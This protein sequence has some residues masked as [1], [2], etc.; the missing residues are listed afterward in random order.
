MAQTADDGRWASVFLINF[1]SPRRHELSC[2]TAAAFRIAELLV[3]RGGR[4]ILLGLS[5]GLSSS[6][7]F[8][9]VLVADTPRHRARRSHRC[10]FALRSSRPTA[11]RHRH[12]SRLTRGWELALRGDRRRSAT[13]NLRRLPGRRGLC[14]RGSVWARYWWRRSIHLGDR[15]SRRGGSPPGDR[16]GLV[17]AGGVANQR[18]GW[19]DSSGCGRSNGWDLISYSFYLWHWPVLTIAA[20]RRERRVTVGTSM[21]CYSSPWHW[22]MVTYLLLENPIRHNRFLSDQAL[23]KFGPRRMPDLSSLTV[24]TVETHL[25]DKGRPLPRAWQISRRA[26]PCPSP[27]SGSWNSMGT[28]PTTS[29]RLVA[30]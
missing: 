27:T 1:I 4:A 5:H 11:I 28:G 18:T 9:R 13:V 20:E 3:S 17:I 2:P 7:I 6:S 30:R 19:S 12:T 10:S 16:D 22:P 29:H 21:L 24:A 23:G 8:S 26:I 15:L 14:C 25:H